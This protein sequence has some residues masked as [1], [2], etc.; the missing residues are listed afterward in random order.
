MC[1]Q[2]NGGTT[3][4]SLFSYANAATWVDQGTV[5][6]NITGGAGLARLGPVPQ[7]W[8]PGGGA[9]LAMGG[10]PVPGLWNAFV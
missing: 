9:K 10:P 1:W 4:A 6:C 8:S 2:Q 3:N 7:Q 5:M